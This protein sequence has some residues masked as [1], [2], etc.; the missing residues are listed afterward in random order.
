MV[1]AVRDALPGQHGCISSYN[2]GEPQRAMF[3]YFAGIVTH[4]EPDPA[5]ADATTCNLLLVQGSRSSI[6]VPNDSWEPIWF[7]AR[8][9]DDKELY[10]LYR[11]KATTRS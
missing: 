9:G 5:A 4:R 11:R 7:G 3:Q 2:L 1:V 6:Y 10:R 8:P